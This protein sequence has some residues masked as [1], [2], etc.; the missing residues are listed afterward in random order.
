MSDATTLNC[1]ELQA[2]IESLENGMRVYGDQLRKIEG[3]LTSDG[4]FDDSIQKD[5]VLTELCEILDVNPTA[6]V[7]ITASL[8]VYVSHEV[9]LNELDDFD[10]DQHLSDWLSVEISSG[11]SNVDEWCVDI[12]DWE[13]Q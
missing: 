11:D 13:K 12:A 5:Q 1:T 8:T 10:A 6:T 2:R 7:S 9:P 4:W 3:N